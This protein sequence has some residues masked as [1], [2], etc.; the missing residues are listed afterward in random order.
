M[1]LVAIIGLVGAATLRV[2]ALMQR[3]AAEQELLEMGATF[4][5]ALRSYA[6]ATPPGQ[7]R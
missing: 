3:A 5:E 1:I 7:P 6:D 4:S 2:D